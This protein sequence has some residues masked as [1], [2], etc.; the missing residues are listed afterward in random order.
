VE[1]SEW[2]TEPDAFA[3]ERCK[4]LAMDSSFSSSTFSS[5]ESTDKV[6]VKKFYV[7]EKTLISDFSATILSRSWVCSLSPIVRD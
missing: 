4:I 3:L 2:F 5:G 7:D 1:V 6:S